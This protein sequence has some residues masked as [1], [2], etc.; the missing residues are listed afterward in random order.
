MNKP[1]ILGVSASLRNARRGLGNQDL[2]ASIHGCKDE[3]SLKAFLSQEAALHL[4]HFQEAGRK[5]ELPFDQMYRNLKKL[6][7][8]RG[9]SNSEVALSAALWSCYQLGCDIDHVSLSEYYTESGVHNEQALFDKVKAADGIM[10]STPVYFGDRSSLAQTFL[11]KIRVDQAL[12]ESLQGKVYAGLAV[13]AKRN[14]GQETTLI[15][16]MLDMLNA[17]LLCVGNDSETTSQYGGTGHAGDIGTMPNDDYGL[18]T[19]MG[20]GRR[21]SRVT[22]IMRLSEEYTLK[23]KPRILFWLLQDKDDYALN[24]LTS[25]TA[26]VDANI[27]IMNVSDATVMRCLACDICP[28]HIDV[29]EE[30][31]CIIK[32]SKD[33]MG[34]LHA[35]FMSADAVIPVIYSPR[36]RAGVSSTYQRFLERTRYLRRG[37]Y[38]LSNAISAPFIIEEV[39]AN[40]N[41]HIRAMTSMV[42]HHTVLSRPIIAAKWQDKIIN[43]EDVKREFAR[44]NELICRVMKGRLAAFDA[45]QEHLKYRPIGYVLSAVKDVEDEKLLRR[46]AMMKGRFERN[47]QAKNENIQPKS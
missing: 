13:G 45:K 38:L 25:L 23:G 42:R 17:G 1:L 37:D 44:L 24:Y 18:Q 12:N 28:T 16:H 2:I 7:G 31:R 6:K 26:Q 3:A 9:L 22:Q 35:R 19:A 8:N 5:E 11:E 46:E 33:A 30:Y 27:D 39:G 29:D 20:T 14:G 47:A 36:D 32:S 40:E 41:M 4:E 43:D 10:V 21:L 15:Y 34:D